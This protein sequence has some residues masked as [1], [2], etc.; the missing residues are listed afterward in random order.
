MTQ[1][2]MVYLIHFDTPIS[3]DHTCQHYL[4]SCVDLDERMQTHRVKPDARLLQV[5]KERG[6][7]FRVVRIWEGGRQLE[8][9]LKNLHNGKKLC[10]VCSAQKSSIKS[11]VDFFADDLDAL[12][13]GKVKPL[14]WVDVEAA[15]SER[16]GEDF[17]TQP[18]LY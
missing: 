6:I 15:Y 11:D 18:Y 3:Q 10:P 1:T 17:S 14:C 5:A 7:G 16:V 2:T 9:K 13:Q 12:R 8:R 4:G